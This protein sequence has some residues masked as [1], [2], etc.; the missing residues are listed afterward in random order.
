MRIEQL[1]ELS[2]DERIPEW[3]VSK[4]VDVP[5]FPGAKLRFVFDSIGGDG[6]SDEFA[7]AVRRFL[8][9]TV[10]DRDEAAQYVFA[11]YREMCEAIGA[12]EVGVSI[13]GAADVWNHVRPDEIH[14]TR[15]SNGDRKVYVRI[16]AECAWEPEHGLQIVYREGWEL[17]RVSQQDGH[18]THVDAFALPESEDRIV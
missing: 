17:K 4:R 9:L 12:D 6:A 7:S 15:R 11:N 2:P 13:D 14:V 1:G 8:S 10:R 18:L 3:L 5:Y 16:T